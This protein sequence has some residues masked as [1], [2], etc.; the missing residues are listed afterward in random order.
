MNQNNKQKII[1][2]FLMYFL[3]FVLYYI[4][5]NFV[6][7]NCIKDY[8]IKRKPINIEQN[9]T[10][11][12]K[13]IEKTEKPKEID[14]VLIPNNF[15][16]LSYKEAF[17]KK[18]LP[19][20]NNANDNIKELTNYEN[21]PVSLVLSQSIIESNWGRS[22]FSKEYNNLFGVHE[23]KAKGNRPVKKYLSKFGSII[24]YMLLLHKGSH[25]KQFRVLLKETND[26]YKLADGLLDYS[27]KGY[28]YIKLVKCVIKDNNLKQYD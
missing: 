8:N 12:I 10:E 7:F 26:S 6:Y 14:E 11:Q 27:E 19:I 21:I 4:L 17:I 24:D 15:R 9:N 20:I 13:Q 16:Q 22:R 25:F 18:M 3:F 1:I 5:I 28:D 23:F 2:K